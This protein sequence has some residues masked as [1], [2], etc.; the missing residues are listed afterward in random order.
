M[1]TEISV[2]ANQPTPSLTDFHKY[3]GRWVAVAVADGRILASG[4]S[5]IEAAAAADALGISVAD[6][7]LEP[8]PTEDTLLM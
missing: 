8:I 3:R 2:L 5:V 6:Y 1:M 7:L 4:Q